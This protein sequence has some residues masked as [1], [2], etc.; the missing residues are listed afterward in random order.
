MKKIRSKPAG[1]NQRLGQWGEGLAAVYLEERGLRIV[2]RN[3]RCPLGE[4]DLIAQDGD[5]LVFC[6][7]KTRRSTAF[8]QPQEAVALAKQRKI[9]RSATWYIAARQWSTDVRFDVVAISKPT[10]GEPVIEWLPA[11]FFIS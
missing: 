11:A 8:G 3:F 10:A 4:I 1:A 9:I 2:E 7:V 6:E 5:C